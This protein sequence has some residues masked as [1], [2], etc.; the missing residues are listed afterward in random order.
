M[1]L[2]KVQTIP[3]RATI[4][5]NLNHVVQFSRRPT[6][7]EVQM[8]TGDVH[9]LNMDYTHFEMLMK[10]TSVSVINLTNQ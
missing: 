10:E 5:I 4:T 1:T 7:V 3:D 9:Q 6:S 8:V 2:L